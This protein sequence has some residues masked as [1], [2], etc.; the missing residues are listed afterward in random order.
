[1]KVHAYETPQTFPMINNNI[2]ATFQRISS[3]SHPSYLQSFPSLR[4]KR[5]H[6]ES[7]VTHS[8]PLDDSALTPPSSQTPTSAHLPSS[9]VSRYWTSLASSACCTSGSLSREKSRYRVSQARPTMS[10]RT[11][12]ACSSGLI[13]SDWPI[14]LV[15][16]WRGGIVRGVTSG[17][18]ILEEG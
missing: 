9:S 4:E 16:A 14:L 12:I 7:N 18:I 15:H 3:K 8:P 1:M 5:D 13:H 10:R 2:P 11:R 6:N 17:E